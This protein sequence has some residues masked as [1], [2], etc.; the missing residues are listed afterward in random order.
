MHKNL[1]GH[2]IGASLPNPCFVTGEVDGSVLYNQ[3]SLRIGDKCFVQDGW[4]ILNWGRSHS[5]HNL[6]SSYEYLIHYHNENK[7]SCSLNSHIGPPIIMTI[8][9][10][11]VVIFGMYILVFF[12]HV[13]S[14]SYTFLASVSRIT[15]WPMTLQKSKS[16]VAQQQRTRT[17]FTSTT[18]TP[19]TFMFNSLGKG[20]YITWTPNSPLLRVIPHSQFFT[21]IDQ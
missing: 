4:Q 19:T 15:M 18:H 10:G 13:S 9:P 1:P 8:E 6:W 21:N 2:F 12:K 14:F 20:Q 7:F 5:P 16:S 3:A 11:M 17:R